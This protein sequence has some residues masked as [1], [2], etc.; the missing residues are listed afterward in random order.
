MFV[1]FQI[2]R[3][4]NCLIAAASVYV[5]AYLTPHFNHSWVLLCACLSAL[6][7]TGAGNV[8]NDLFDIKI[9]QQ[10]KPL[11]PLAS[12]R[13]TTKQASIWATILF[14]LGCIIVLPFSSL[15]FL[16][17]VITSLLLVLYAWRLKKTALWGNLL[18]SSLTALAFIYGAIAVQGFTWLYYPAIFSFLFHFGREIS[19]DIEDMAG[20]KASSAATLPL[21]IGVTGAKSIITLV[22]LLLMAITIFPY[23]KGEYN[24]K[25]FLTVLIGVDFFL[26]TIL[27][28]IWL[29]HDKEKLNKINFLLKCN[30]PVGLIALAMNKF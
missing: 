9:D 30:M 11:R 13:M 4:L 10:N 26:L 14:I 7:I 2:L 16:I 22:Y 28:F 20:D 19:K 21:T 8:V 3:P 12:G 27:P 6:L 1:Y 5:G 29:T 25:Y 18:V 24:T 23:V 15:L 17:A